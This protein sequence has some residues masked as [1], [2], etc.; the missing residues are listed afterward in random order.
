MGALHGLLQ[1]LPGLVEGEFGLFDA[2]FAPPDPIADGPSIEDGHRQAEEEALVDVGADLVAEGPRPVVVVGEGAGED[3]LQ[4]CLGHT[5][6]EDLEGGV[7]DGFLR[8][9]GETGA[10]A[11]AGGQPGHARGLREVEADLLLA[12]AGFARLDFGEGGQGG[13]Q[14]AVEGGEGRQVAHAAEFGPLDGEVLGIF[15][16][17][18]HGLGELQPGE[19]D[20]AFR[21]DF[22]GLVGGELGLQIEQVGFGG[23]A[24]V[25]EGPDAGHLGLG[26]ADVE[27]RDFQGILGKHEAQ[28]GA[29]HLEGDVV[30]RAFEVVLGGDPALLGLIEAEVVGHAPEEGDARSH[31]HGVGPD[32]GGGELVGERVNGLSP[33]VSV[34]RTA[35]QVRQEGRP[36]LLDIDVI[37]GQA[38]L[39]L[40][41][42]QVV[43]LRMG[44]GT[45]EGPRRRLGLD[46]AGRDEQKE[47]KGSGETKGGNPRR[48]GGGAEGCNH[49]T[50]VRRP[51]KRASRGSSVGQDLD[52]DAAIGFVVPRV[53]GVREE[54]GIGA[55]APGF[56]AFGGHALLDEPGDEGLG[57]ALGDLSVKG[58]APAAIGAIGMADDPKVDVGVGFEPGEEFLGHLEALRMETL[59]I[60][61][62]VD[63]QNVGP[64]TGR[65]GAQGNPDFGFAE[66]VGPERLGM[67][68]VAGLLTDDGVAAVRH[69]LE[70]RVPHGGPAAGAAILVPEEHDVTFRRQAVLLHGQL[71]L[72][73]T[74]QGLGRINGPF[75]CELGLG[76]QGNQQGEGQGEKGQADILPTLAGNKLVE[77]AY[78]LRIIRRIS[79]F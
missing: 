11:P 69:D 61:L 24:G 63:A 26:R 68:H 50:K 77:H 56:E 64:E 72:A 71:E 3:R 34:G 42:L 76:G 49:P 16:A 22:G 51:F 60:A 12:D 7:P 35:V 18:A 41:D 79:T 75:G 10:V 54:Q 74:Q 5:D 58:A 40:P 25:D 43:V 38:E 67:E 1:G 27:G 70:E 62:E 46:R 78:N 48:H 65:Q 28:K 19:R 14:H 29:G 30:A 2:D 36:G 13:F 66:Q 47:K 52:L 73:G 32:A 44:N 17:Q 31:A 4:A 23:G 37:P 55:A 57:P 45:V 15:R 39:A 8:S 21:G 20:V 33:V 6:G 59:A 53:D 9:A